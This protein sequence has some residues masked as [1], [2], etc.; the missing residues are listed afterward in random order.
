MHLTIA[1]IRH[2][3]VCCNFKI[4]S[5]NVETDETKR[6]SRMDLPPVLVVSST[7]YSRRAVRFLHYGLQKFGQ[8]STFYM[9]ALKLFLNSDAPIVRL[10]CTATIALPPLHVIKRGQVSPYPSRE[11][12]RVARGTLMLHPKARMDE[13]TKR[14]NER[15]EIRRVKVRQR[16]REGG[17]RAIRRLLLRLLQSEEEVTDE[18]GRDPTT[19]RKRK[20]ETSTF[21]STTERGDARVDEVDDVALGA[22]R[23]FDLRRVVCTLDGLLGGPEDKRAHRKCGQGDVQHVQAGHRAERDVSLDVRAQRRGELTQS[24]YSLMTTSISVVIVHRTTVGGH[25]PL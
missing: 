21:V 4:F 8:H 2:D 3:T 18:E 9:F 6:T 19:K 1:S 16:E 12:L 22:R 17:E 7:S 20:R 15:R 24:T 13:P 11:L 14:R 10:G 23:Q 5:G 25:I